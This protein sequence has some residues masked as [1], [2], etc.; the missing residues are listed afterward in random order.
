MESI[1]TKPG[2]GTYTI[3]LLFLGVLLSLRM[4]DIWVATFPTIAGSPVSILDPVNSLADPS[5]FGIPAAIIPS[6]SGLEF[7]DFSEVLDS[8]PGGLKA[9]SFVG[10]LLPSGMDSDNAEDFTSSFKDASEISEELELRRDSEW[11]E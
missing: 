5:G 2:F 9:E 6:E 4:D 8:T 10:D 7:G 1:E 3:P 11:L